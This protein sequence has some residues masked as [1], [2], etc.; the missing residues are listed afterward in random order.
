MVGHIRPAGSDAEEQLAQLLGS[1]ILC[2]R[3]GRILQRDP[4]WARPHFLDDR[5]HSYSNMQVLVQD[6]R[7]QGLLPAPVS[8]RLRAHTPARPDGVT[9]Q[10]TLSDARALP[11]V[12][13]D[14]SAPARL[15]AAMQRLRQRSGLSQTQLARDARVS[16]SYVSRLEGGQRTP[17]PS[18]LE[19]LVRPLHVTSAQRARLVRLREAAASGRQ[20]PGRC[21][22]CDT[23]FTGSPQRRYCSTRCR[24]RA[25]QR[26]WKEEGRRVGG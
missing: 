18:V 11:S 26:R 3:C 5:G 12:A 15:G 17:S 16:L 7:Q 10:Q 8:R 13:R 20:V 23:A 22:A 1:E 25:A 21:A 4:L 24:V 19:A 14:T 9:M 2:P 6:L